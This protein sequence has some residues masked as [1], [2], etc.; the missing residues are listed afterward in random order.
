MEIHKLYEKLLKNNEQWVTD[1]LKLDPNYFKEMAKGQEPKFLWIGCSDSRVPASEITQTE[2]GEMFEHRNIANIV[3]HT[4]MNALSVIHY[5]VK[6]LK[7]HHIIVCGHY[8]C[9]GVRAALTNNN[10][11]IIDNWIRNIKDVYRLHKN[12]FESISDK[13][14]MEKKLIELNVLEQVFNICKTSVV[15]EAWAEGW[16]LDVH[17]W[18]YDIESGRIIDQQVTVRT[19]Q[20]LESIYRFDM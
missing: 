5:A 2:P 1:K 9:G 15:Q 14:Q 4:D 13:E 17:G 3:D 11:G 16:R 6:V 10:Y 12:E 18:V 20:E 7:V 19:N 8:G